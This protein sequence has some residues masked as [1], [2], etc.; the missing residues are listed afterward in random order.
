MSNQLA[1]LINTAT[2]TLRADN[3]AADLQYRH[4]RENTLDKL[5]RE[6]ILDSGYQFV[7]GG[8]CNLL[9]T[10]ADI[11][12]QEAHRSPDYEAAARLIEDCAGACDLKYAEG[13]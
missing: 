12:D 4:Q 10:I 13:E 1:A 11:C 3:N 8:V 7:F 6:Y 9:G 2:D 5:L